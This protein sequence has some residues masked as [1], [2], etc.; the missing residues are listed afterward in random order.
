MDILFEASYDTDIMLAS[1]DPS[2]VEPT[3]PLLSLHFP[4]TARKTW[5]LK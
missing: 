1:H 3:H 4:S 5:N 2:A